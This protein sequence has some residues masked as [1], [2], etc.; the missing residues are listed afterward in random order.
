MPSLADFPA[1]GKLLD[2]R[3]ADHGRLVTFQPQGT[4]YEWHLRAEDGFEA[5][6]L[7]KPTELLIRVQARKVYTVPSGG[8]FVQ[9]IFGPPR[10]IQGRV[11]WVDESG[12]RIVV[13]A[14]VP[15]II[16]LPAADTAID[17]SEGPIT[18]GRMV[19]VVALP[20]VTAAAVQL[21]ERAVMR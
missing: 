10:I 8:N 12:Q 4:N 17:Q 6:P 13:H 15:F 14:T 11:K 1:K 16:E 7:N 5:P 2:V 18:Q 3:D 9:P 21:A 19:N 20:G